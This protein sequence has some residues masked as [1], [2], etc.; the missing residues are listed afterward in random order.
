MTGCDRLRSA[1][2]HRCASGCTDPISVPFYTIFKQHAGAELYR[3]RILYK[4]KGGG[5]APGTDT[6]KAAMK[7]AGSQRER[8]CAL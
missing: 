3:I 2:T 5:E 4:R 7:R 6:S 1:R 8:Y